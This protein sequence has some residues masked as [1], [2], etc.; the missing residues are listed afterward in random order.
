MH[1]RRTAC[2]AAIARRNLRD[3][4]PIAAYG[5]VQSTLRVECDQ[6][7]HLRIESSCFRKIVRGAYRIHFGKTQCIVRV[8]EPRIDVL[9]R[10]INDVSL[11]R[12]EADDAH[13]LHE[14]DLAVLNTD[15]GILK[16]GTIAQMGCATHKY[17]GLGGCGGRRWK[18]GAGSIRCNQKE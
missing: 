4:Y 12:I 8:D 1:H 18:L 11:L 17:N 16:H 2:N 10:H 5:V 6:R 3:E 14:R 7:P 15:S 9:A 13:G